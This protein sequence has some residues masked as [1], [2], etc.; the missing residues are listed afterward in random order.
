[1]S[2]PEKND[3]RH[4]TSAERQKLY[5]ERAEHRRRAEASAKEKKRRRIIVLAAAAGVAFAALAV[6]L[7]LLISRVIIPES[8]YKNAVDLYDAGEYAA[9][10][11]AFDAMGDYRDSRE[12]VKKCILEQARALAG[13]DDVITGTSADM[14]WFSFDTDDDEKGILKFDAEVYR[15]GGD[16]AVPD[17]FDGVLVR[18]IA[19]RAFYRCDFLTSV[20]LP[21][22]VRV[23]RERAF[24]ECPKLTA[25]EL[26]DALTEIGE[27]AFGKC[28]ALTAVSFGNGIRTIAQRAFDGCSALTLLSLPE[29]L[30]FIGYRAF[31]ACAGL[32][33]VSLP[34]SLETVENQAF[35]G[36]ESVKKL[37]YPGSR[38]R[39][40]AVLGEGGKPLLSAGEIITGE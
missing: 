7:V 26:P 23:I 2:E 15:G 35:I 37:E 3:G 22:S 38:A 28:T 9:A 8:R 39:L 18:G 14:P 32:D 17:V 31:G 6:G 29:G 20:S 12:Y 1:M 24:Y 27:Y 33:A 34:A 13:R 19:V 11:D 5:R 21:P 30:T 40:E 36:C 10:M 25:A 4:L 16:I